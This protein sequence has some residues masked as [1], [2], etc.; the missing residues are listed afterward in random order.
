MHVKA[1][2]PSFFGSVEL[3][4]LCSFSLGDQVGHGK[5]VG[6]LLRFGAPQE[7]LLRSWIRCYLRHQLE[8]WHAFCFVAHFGAGLGTVLGM[9]PGMVGRGKHGRKDL[10]PRPLDSQGMCLAVAPSQEPYPK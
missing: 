5:R 8:A 2:L 6:W 7:F 9:V 10:N 3:G 1:P 4:L